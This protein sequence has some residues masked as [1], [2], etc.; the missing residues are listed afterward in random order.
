M[1]KHPAAHPAAGSGVDG[2]ASAAHRPQARER[3]RAVTSAAPA[4]P[5]PFQQKLSFR[6]QNLRQPRPGS[7]CRAGPPGWAPCST[8]AAASAQDRQSALR[9]APARGLRGDAWER[10]GVRS[11]SRH[12]QSGPLSACIPQGG[13]PRAG[14]QWEWFSS[15][16]S[17]P[18]G[19]DVDTS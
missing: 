10:L 18:G 14:R 19:Y 8:H 1:E 17:I 7:P 6:L 12:R 11:G 15:L 13:L 9:G 5:Q 3:E 2:P 16:A 4:P